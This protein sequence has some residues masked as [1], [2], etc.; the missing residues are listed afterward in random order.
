MSRRRTVLITGATG[1]LGQGLY[2]TAPEE[3]SIVGLHLRPYGSE[4]PGIVERVADV[5]SRQTLEPLFSEFQFDAVIHAAGDA[6]VDHSERQPDESRES[7]VGGTSNV[8][9]LCAASG[10]PLVYVST[11]AVFDGSGAPYRESDPV[12]PINA[13][14]RIKVVCEDVVRATLDRWTIVRPI[15]MYGWPHP[16]GRPNP[17]TWV[18]DALERGETIHVVDDVYEN[19]LHNLS[20]A[21]AIWSALDRDVTGVVHLA[22]RDVYSRYELART[23]ARTFALDGARIKAVSSDYF[24]GIARRPRNTS[25]ATTRMEFELG[26]TPSTLEEGLRIMASK[27]RARA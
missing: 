14:G 4:R 13:Y 25:L 24:P 20:A 17:V 8:A 27:A 12:N 5:R 1:L 6:S 26:V 2:A 18:I 22:G 16:E 10:V 3:W 15:L 7:N 9:H 21:R 11:N 23:V 19:T